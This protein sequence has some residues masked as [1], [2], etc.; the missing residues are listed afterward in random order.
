[1]Q[2][3]YN[4]V[5]PRVTL[6]A[7]GVLLQITAGQYKSFEIIDLQLNQETINTSATHTVEL[8]AMT[9]PATGG[10]ATTPATIRAATAAAATA[11]A[12]P[13][14]GQGTAGETK[15]FLGWN[16]VN[17]SLAKTPVP[18]ARLLIN[19][20]ETVALRLVTSPPS[21]VVFSGQITI[22]ER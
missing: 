3:T 18:D 9:S 17:G 6:S 19:P 16:M 7:A 13:F 10:A 8:A 12:G 20:G 21:P 14:S 4:V 22:V 5:I 11:A 2:Q 1:M 15:M